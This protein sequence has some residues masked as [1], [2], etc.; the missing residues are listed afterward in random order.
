MSALKLIVLLAL[1]CVTNG[2]VI[3]FKGLEL[4]KHA[5]LSH[6]DNIKDHKIEALKSLAGKIIIE[7]PYAPP[8]D[9]PTHYGETTTTTAAPP[10]P[11][12]PYAPP[13]SPPTHYGETTTTTTAAPPPTTVTVPVTT[14]PPPPPP[15]PPTTTTTTEVPTYP[16]YV[17]A[18]EYGPPTDPPI[19]HPTIPP[20]VP[21][22]EYG[23]P[24]DP[25][26]EL[27]TIPP[28]VPHTEYGIPQI[29]V[30]PEIPE[31]ITIPPPEPHNPE[32]C[33]KTYLQPVLY[34]VQE[35]FGAQPDGEIIVYPPTSDS[36]PDP[37]SV[38]IPVKSDNVRPVVVGELQEPVIPVV[39]TLPA[40]TVQALPVIEYSQ[41][42]QG[43]TLWGADAIVFSE[44]ETPD[45]TSTAEFSGYEYE[46]PQPVSGLNV[47]W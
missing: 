23:P 47:P 9:P 7:K 19:E 8:V 1:G 20:Y 38:V 29:P 16:P 3:P 35:T 44:V 24:T 39:E 37:K 25:P 30:I 5:F 6:V 11:P 14:T 45:Q 10:P 43:N 34:Q 2:F 28:Y 42:S 15:P 27:P 33:P 13:V 17:P 36:D 4:K 32:D 22:I 18:K 41:G 12:F 21:H 26:I 46:M 40:Q 31:I